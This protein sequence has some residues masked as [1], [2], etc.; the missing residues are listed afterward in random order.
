MRKLTF[1]VLVMMAMAFV[2][3]GGSEVKATST[4][5]IDSTAV[6]TVVTDSVISDTVNADSVITDSIV[7]E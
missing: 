2:G 5:G 6:D 1:A 4:D 3:C 7:A